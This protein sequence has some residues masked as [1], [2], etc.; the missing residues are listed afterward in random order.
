MDLLGLILPK[1]RPSVDGVISEP[2]VYPED[3]ILELKKDGTVW[4]NLQAFTEPYKRIRVSYINAARDRHVEFA[5]R[6]DSFIRKTRENRI[7]RGYG[8][9]EIYYSQEYSKWI[10]TCGR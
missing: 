2:Y 6:L 3:I 4:K 10:R 9:V 7:I 1:V 8:G 5:K